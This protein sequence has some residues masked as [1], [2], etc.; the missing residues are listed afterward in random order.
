MAKILKIVHPRKHYEE[1]FMMEDCQANG[2]NSQF[3]LVRD[4]K[5]K[6]ISVE[7]FFMLRHN[8]FSMKLTCLNDRPFSSIQPNKLSSLVPI[9]WQKQGDRIC[10]MKRFLLML[11]DAHEQFLLCA[12]LP[13]MVPNSS[14]E[15]DIIYNVTVEQIC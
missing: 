4:G 9:Q 14:P 13:I 7:L 8:D 6:E 12:C 11:N 10:S 2:K 3:L 5:I 15:I 1:E